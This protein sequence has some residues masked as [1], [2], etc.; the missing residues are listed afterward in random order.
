MLCQW[1]LQQCSTNPKFPAMESRIFT[2]SMCADENPH[3]ILPSHHQQR[4]SNIWAGICGHNLFRPHVLPNTLTG[5]NYKAFL[6][7]KMPDFLVNVS[8]I[9]HQELHFM[10]DGASTHFSLI[11]CRYLNR[12]FLGQWI[13]RCGPTAWPL[14]SPHLN[15]LNFYLWGHLKSLVYLSPVDDMETLWNRIVVG[16][17][18][19]HNMPEI[20]DLQVAMRRRVKAC[21]QAGG[22]HMEHLL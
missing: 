17:Q 6:E 9:I 22:G 21:I 11:A 14:H 1:F 16:F 10:H 3:V 5:Q 15:P 8:L 13:G 19:I 18:T 7:N 20:W 4:F 2:I 12:K